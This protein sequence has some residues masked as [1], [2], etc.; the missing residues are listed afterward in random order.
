VNAVGDAPVTVTDLV[1]RYGDRTVL[2][3]VSF[4]IAPGSL[5]ALLGPNGAGKTTTVEILEGYRRVDAGSVRVL[6]FDPGADEAA[7]RPRVGVM[8]QAGGLYPLATPRELLALFGR[9]FADPIAPDTLIER[10][11]LA[12][13]ADS[14]VRTLSGGERQRLGLALALVGRPELLVLDEPTAGMDPEAKQ[15]TR[16]ILDALRSD[17]TTI[18]L[19]THELSDVERLADHVVVLD[20]GRVVADAAP[21]DIGTAG[22]R[23]I[24]FRVGRRLDDGDLEALGHATGGRAVR[25][26]GGWWR[27]DV[28]VV[29][30]GAVAALASVA[31]AR[32]LLVTELR[33][34]GGTLEERYLEL[35][36]TG[37]GTE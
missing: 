36:G 17:G 31:A 7:L 22:G 9:F 28:S 12:T 27:V 2:D 32:G 24:R 6:G 23:A 11:G 5:T 10:L 20:R 26:P 8:L 21:D 25:E 33:A 4:S 19:T 13:V 34:G 3:G 18:L 35:V 1:K 16:G 37:G 15:S 14:R 30:P 29:D